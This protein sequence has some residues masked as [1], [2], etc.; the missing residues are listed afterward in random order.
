[1]VETDSALARPSQRTDERSTTT[2]SDR[3]LAIM[4]LFP[5]M[6]L[7]LA[8]FL[9]P[10]FVAI[11][12]SFFSIHTL[13]R[14]RAYVGLDNYARLF[15]D[16]VIRDA[17][18]RSLVWTGVGIVGQS[19]LGLLLSLLLNQQL[20]G[21]GILRTLVLFPYV[22]PAI[23][24]ALVWRYLLEPTMGLFNYILRSSGLIATPIAWLAA[25]DTAL[26]AVIIVGIWKYMPFMV[27]LFLARLQTV[28]QE[29]YE[30][31]SIDGGSTWDTFWHITLP[32][33]MPVITVAVLLRTIWAFNE[34]DIVYLLASGGPLN[35]TTT[36]PVVIRQIAFASLNMG[37]ASAVATAM[38]A[39]LLATSALSFW[40][41]G[42][43][44]DRLS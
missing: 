42:K 34:F 5:S 14:A 4:M 28:S 21:R 20:T 8:I 32:W 11:Y 29:L 15:T 44:E 18:W 22:V 12:D 25:P 9:F 37:L 17:F 26:W 41:Y 19:L 30:A 38:A 2:M 36:M 10:F 33:L 24:A 40:I 16:P 27:I 7:L 35:A 43:V 6:G 39:L 1:M 3:R 23:V 31:A 13:T